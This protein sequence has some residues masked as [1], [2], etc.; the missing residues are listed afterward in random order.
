MRTSEKIVTMIADSTGRVIGGPERNRD[1]DPVQRA[2]AGASLASI[3][4]H[5]EHRAGDA[6]PAA[7][8]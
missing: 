1:L 3:R 5:V 6:N 8:R 4:F 2:R 7:D